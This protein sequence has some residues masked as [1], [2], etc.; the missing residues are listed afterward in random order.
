MVG[1]RSSGP[2]TR[3]AAAHAVPAIRWTFRAE[4]PPFSAAF[5]PPYARYEVLRMRHVT[6]PFRPPTFPSGGLLLIA[7]ILAQATLGACGGHDAVNDVSDSDSILVPTVTID[8]SPDLGFGNI[9]S[10]TRFPDGTL[11]IAD[12]HRRSIALFDSLGR[13]VG[14]FGGHGEGPGEFRH[15]SWVGTCG[16]ESLFVWDFM[17][18]RMTVATS[19]GEV[20]RRFR[21]PADGSQGAA[22]VSVACSSTGVFAYQP[23]PHEM[24]RSG[25]DDPHVLRG[26]GPV[27]LGDTY[28]AI[29]ATVEDIPTDEFVVVGGGSGPR[30]LG[31]QTSLAVSQDR[32][33][34]ATGDSSYVE[35][36]DLEGTPFGGVSV[37]SDRPPPTPQAYRQAIEDITRSIHAA[38]VAAHVTRELRAMPMPETLPPYFGAFTDPEG[39][40]WLVRSPPGESPTRL[41]AF[42]SAGRLSGRVALTSAVTVHEI[43]RDYVLGSVTGPSGR[44]KVLLFAMDR[45]P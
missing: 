25:S 43:G 5:P 17:S 9:E 22:P 34:I 28:G 23:I 3:N 45:Q 19:S 1:P 18:G 20:V 40:L 2:S 29:S 13:T 41:E 14:A 36:F 32:L 21:V 26:A 38:E 4:M 39:R 8:G 6:E 44:P 12:G 24:T 31:R 35:A 7:P 16:S 11:A 15:P 37:P 10:A 33:Y 27:W 42:D 30:P